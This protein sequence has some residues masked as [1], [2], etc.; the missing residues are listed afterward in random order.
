MDDTAHRPGRKVSEAMKSFFEK[1]KEKVEQYR[2]YS[3]AYYKARKEFMNSINKEVT[4]EL[5]KEEIELKKKRFY[6]SKKR[7]IIGDIPPIVEDIVISFNW[8]LL[9]VYKKRLCCSQ[10]CWNL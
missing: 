6:E 2:E 3:R 7:P 1:N 9:A 5:K 10:S 4:N 8:G